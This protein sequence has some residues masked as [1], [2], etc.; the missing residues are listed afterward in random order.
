MLN[1]G[2]NIILPQGMSQTGQNGEGIITADGTVTDEGLFSS[3]LQGVVDT[4]LQETATVTMDLEALLNG[5]PEL[6]GE[7]P[8]ELLMQFVE[9]GGQDVAALEAFLQGQ[10]GMDIQLSQDLAANLN[11]ALALLNGQGVDT[12]AI[13]QAI[14]PK[15]LENGQVKLVNSEDKG[16]LQFQ[17]QQGLLLK[18]NGQQLGNQANLQA[19]LGKG[20]EQS[21]KDASLLDI[22]DEV[23]PDA[24]KM[25]T[26]ADERIF[27]DDNF[28]KQLQKALNPNAGQSQVAKDGLTFNPATTPVTQ[29]SPDSPIVVRQVQVAVP[30]TQGDWGNKFNDQVMW[31]SQQQIKAAAISLNPPELGPVDIKI[32]IVDDVASVQFNSHSGQVREAIE[33]ALPRLRDMMADHGVQLNDV[34][35]SDNP[36][37][38][39]QKQGLDKDGNEA[40]HANDF[41]D[42]AF[43]NDG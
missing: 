3:M 7:I 34:N 43:N 37:K 24:K 18:N 29:I 26:E 21:A 27:K 10:T 9:S 25:L 40:Q 1:V 36:N 22:I 33:Q 5:H 38:Q 12:Q 30:V 8:Q 32:K 11:Q 31:L 16:L 28:M 4:N 35:V 19:D 14:D 17:N 15:L 39:A 13:V 6:E 20:G 42:T 2:P 41:F 23:S